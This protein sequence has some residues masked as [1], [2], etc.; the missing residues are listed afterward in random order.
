MTVNRWNRSPGAI[1]RPASIYAASDFFEPLTSNSVI[2][3]GFG[4]RFYFPTAL[5]VIALQVVPDP[6]ADG[7]AMTE[8]ASETATMSTSQDET[9]TLTLKSLSDSRKWQYCELVFNYSDDR[10][11]YLQHSP[12]GPVPDS[13]GGTTWTSTPWQQT[14][15]AE[16][17]DKNGPQWWSMDDVGVMG[18]RTG[19]RGGVS[20]VFG[21]TLPP[22]AP[23]G[24][25]PA[26]YEVFNTAKT[27]YN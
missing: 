23:C 8:D 3:P 6:Q 2:P 12:S 18:S 20:M 21:A 25:R 13:T 1:R 9:M 16:S 17:V 14:Y 4:G 10:L 24:L 27:Q 5:G 11:R 22:P 7:A 19:D 26:E 15:G